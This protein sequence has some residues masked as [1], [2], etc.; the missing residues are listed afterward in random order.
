MRK[1]TITE[2]FIAI[3]II[4]TAC[5]PGCGTVQNSAQ[6]GANN[7]TGPGD[8]EAYGVRYDVPETY[9]IYM[10]DADQLGTGDE[11]IDLEISGHE[12]KPT[13]PKDSETI[14]IDG[15]EC[16]LFGDYTSKSL[17]I[18]EAGGNK[19]I[20]IRSDF[21]QDPDE[22]DTFYKELLNGIQYTDDEGYVVCRDYISVGGVRIPA[23]GLNP[24]Q[25]FYGLM[26]VE[27]T[28]GLVSVQIDFDDDAYRKGLEQTF[29]GIEKD[30]SDTLLGSGTIEIN[31]AECRWY[32]WVDGLA[33]S[34]TYMSHVIMIPIDEL[35][36]IMCISYDFDADVEDLT[37]YDDR[38]KELDELMKL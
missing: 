17:L 15:R 13:A 14:E 4:M 18:P 36:T 33:D 37:R 2:V 3:V 10:F 11:W 12:G 25:F 7:A 8:H 28:D 24:S 1:R 35:Q 23:K 16:Y 29:A 27:A 9:W 5:L 34:M 19:Y 21:I 26:D 30:Y 31:G 22:A 6:K 32:T 38:I 20:E